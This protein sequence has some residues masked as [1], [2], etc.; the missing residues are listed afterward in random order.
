MVKTIE[1]KLVAT[2][3]KFG[4]VAARFNSFLVDPLIQ[5]AIDTIVRHGGNESDITVVRVPGSFEL[6]GAAKVLAESQQ[7]DGIITLGVVIRGST[8]HYDHV[9]SQAT[10]GIGALSSTLKIPVLFGM[11]TADSIEQAIE[12][13]GTKAGNKGADAAL[14]CIEMINLYAQLRR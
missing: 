7:L 10:S 13:C 6:P 14:G 9:C 2:G 11:V 3:L 4:I 1:G 8:S 12:R 5:G